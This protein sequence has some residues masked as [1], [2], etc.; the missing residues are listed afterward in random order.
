MHA[1]HATQSICSPFRMS[2]PVGQ[3][4]TQ[5]R[6]STQSPVVLPFLPRGSPRLSSYA[7]TSESSTGHDEGGRVRLRRAIGGV[8]LLS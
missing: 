7:T 2:M 5:R 1:V 8:I 3:T 4:A 6:Q